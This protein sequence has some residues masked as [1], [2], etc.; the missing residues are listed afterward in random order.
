[1]ISTKTSL[2]KRIADSIGINKRFSRRGR[3]FVD[4][5]PKTIVS[6]VDATLFCHGDIDDKG[7][8]ISKHGK[9][10]PL[11]RLIGKYATKF[12]GGMYLNLYL[13]P[14]NKHYFVLPYD[15]TIKYI[16]KND[17]RALIP[18]I[19]GLDNIFGNQT[20]FSKA[21]LR[22]ASIGIVIDTGKFSYALIAVGSLNVNNITVTCN[23]GKKYRKGDYVG[24][25][26]VGSTVI[27]CFDKSLKKNSELLIKND[28][29]IYIGGRI[30]KIKPLRQS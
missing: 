9:V 6:P 26:A 22:N 20:W 18:T 7:N 16:Q 17:G 4:K 28:E 5:N 27:L 30:M 11:T 1:M 24:H 3:D 13:S 19:I 23:A 2:L 21:T 25:F 15:G 29:A 14:K 10:V 8:I 12:K